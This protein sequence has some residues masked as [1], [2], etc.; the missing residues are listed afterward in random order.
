[1]Q[2]GWAKRLRSAV[3]TLVLLAPALAGAQ[4]FSPTGAGSA[5]LTLDQD[6][7]YSETLFGKR[8]QSEIEAASDAL[9]ER[10]RALT[11]ELTA[12]E[13]APVPAKKKT[14]AAKKPRKSTRKSTPSSRKRRP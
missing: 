3:L 7:L 8:L 1:M 4:V 9:A 10:N 13:L 11:E 6:R 12:E 2:N 14:P 5:L